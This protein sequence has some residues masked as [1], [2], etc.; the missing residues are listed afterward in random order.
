MGFLGNLY[1]LSAL[2]ERMFV[3]R[4]AKEI[5]YEGLEQLLWA[6]FSPQ[7]QAALKGRI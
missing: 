4:A 7:E 3:L 2:K 5:A 1:N 6:L